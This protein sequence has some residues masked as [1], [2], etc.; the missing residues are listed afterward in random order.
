SSQAWAAPFCSQAGTGW[1]IAL[2]IAGDI[3]G[4]ELGFRFGEPLDV[5]GDGHPDIAA[6]ARFKLQ[7]GVHPNGAAALWSGA[8]GALIRAW[9]GE[10][11]DGLF[12]HWVLPVPKLGHA[13]F[14]DVVI[15]A[16]N[17]RVDGVVRGVLMMRSP[18]TGEELWR[19]AGTRNENL[20]W[21]LA[22]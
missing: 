10:F 22:L 3:P 20:G 9:D 17:A 21:D 15:A 6:G 5:D 1:C 18:Q 7:A 8:N 11:P 12:G 2:R 19:R 4:G 14:A 16:P 13:G